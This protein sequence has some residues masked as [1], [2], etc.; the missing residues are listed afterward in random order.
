MEIMMHHP[1]FF[2]A[3]IRDWKMLLKPDKYKNIVLSQLKQL[4]DQDS[5]I[6]YA[7][8]IMNNHIHLIWQVKNRDKPSEIQKRFL[9]GTS[10][11]IKEDLLVNH[12]EV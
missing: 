6:L 11:K 1:V 5:I 2:T 9:E 4:V 8:C 7:Y 3:T 12:R 10:K